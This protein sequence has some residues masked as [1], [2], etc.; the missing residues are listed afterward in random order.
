MGKKPDTTLLLEAMETG[1]DPNPATGG[2][3]NKILSSL[4][5]GEH[6]KGILAN[7]S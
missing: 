1:K 5:M 6:A 3:G 7:G 2:A 4:S